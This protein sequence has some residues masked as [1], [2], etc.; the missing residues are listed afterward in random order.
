MFAPTYPGWE[1]LAASGVPTWWAR[2]NGFDG[3]HYQMI[4]TRGYRAADLIQAFF[5]IYPLLITG[6]TGII[7]QP[8]V[9][10]LLISLVATGIMLYCL[11]K[12]AREKWGERTAKWLAVLM[13][14][15]PASF[16]LVAGYNESLFLLWLVVAWWFYEQKKYGWTVVFCA[17]LSGTRIVGVILPLTLMLDYGVKAWRR[18]NHQFKKLDYQRLALLF[19]GVS[20]LLVYMIYLWLNFGDP[21]YFM[22]VQS[23]FGSGRETAGLVLLPQVIYRYLKMLVVGLP[24]TWKTWA[25][26]QEF[27]WSLLYLSM[28]V[29]TGWKNWRTKKEIVPWTW[30][31]FSVGAYLVPT[32]TGNFSSMP[33][34]ILVC[35]VVPLFWAQSL[36]KKATWWQ[37]LL[38][39]LSFLTMLLNLTLFVQGYWV[40]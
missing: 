6:L 24:P 32:L 10:S 26:I 30:W 38:L 22:T 27:F 12:L 25:V 36:A 4:A 40:A 7:G 35:L 28:L 14:I 1:E 2:L 11:A 37:Y 17:L 39:L 33:R 20:G 23:Q 21:F 19:L 3:V 31:L 16:Y 15:L 34:Y 13:L 29:W 9:A 5:P 18:Q 8:V